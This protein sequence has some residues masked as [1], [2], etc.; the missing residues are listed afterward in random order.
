M[1]MSSNQLRFMVIFTLG[2]IVVV[3]VVLYS[4]GGNQQ[5]SRLSSGQGD[6]IPLRSFGNPGARNSTASVDPCKLLLQEEI[7]A[8]MGLPVAE[9]QSGYVENPLGE[10]YCRFPNPDNQSEYLFYFSIVFNDSIVPLLLNDGYSV[11]R[12]FD[13]RKASPELIQPVDDL[14]DD[15]FW[16]GSGDE[17]W[18]GLHILV[19]DVYVKVNV[20]SGDAELDYRVARNLSVAALERLFTP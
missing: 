1:D 15:A 16:G 17:L 6:S 14:G 4:A 19:H 9:A 2:L 13:G 8:E 3:A 7:E 5:T 18:N 20:F 10:R 12:M 11:K